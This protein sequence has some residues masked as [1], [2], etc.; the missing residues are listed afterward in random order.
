[1]NL[2]MARSEKLLVRCP[3]CAR[4]T[5][6]GL[7]WLG[8]SDWV[9]CPTCDP[10]KPGLMPIVMTRFTNGIPKRGL[11]TDSLIPQVEVAT[12]K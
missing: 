4:S 3:D 12:R 5:R 11:I 6:P 7:L 9:E 2:H 10:K 8:G 1:M